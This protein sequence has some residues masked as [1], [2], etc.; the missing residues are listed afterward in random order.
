M[1]NRLVPGLAIVVAIVWAAAFLDGVVTK[2]YTPLG[3]TTSVMLVVTG[4]LFAVRNGG[5]PR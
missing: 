4:A 3:I 2:D 5:G 1:K